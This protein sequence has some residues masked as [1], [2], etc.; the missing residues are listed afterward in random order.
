MSVRS[1]AVVGKRNEPLYLR[2]FSESSSDT[3]SDSDLFGFPS[4]LAE[5]ET[6][7]VRSCGSKC[8]IRQQFIL[9]AALDRVEELDGPPPGLAWREPGV[10]GADA[11]WLGLLNITD[12]LRVY[13]KDEN[14]FLAK[15][16]ALTD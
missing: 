12:G 14:M 1:L 13:G 5:T 3:F 4:S 15:L 7:A 16:A 8:S 9:N 2:E 6:N 11:M 10:K